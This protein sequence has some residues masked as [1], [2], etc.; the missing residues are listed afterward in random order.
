MKSSSRQVVFVPTDD[1][2]VRMSLPTRVLETRDDDSQ[3]V[4]IL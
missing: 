2:N 1:D 4:S 3:D